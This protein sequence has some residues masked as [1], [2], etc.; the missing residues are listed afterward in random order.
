MIWNVFMVAA[1]VICFVIVAYCVR[2][3]LDKANSALSGREEIF[4]LVR[5]CNNYMPMGDVFD[6]L[7]ELLKAHQESDHIEY[8]GHF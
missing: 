5:S 7:S 6:K 3:S 4:S 8:R 1:L 2:K